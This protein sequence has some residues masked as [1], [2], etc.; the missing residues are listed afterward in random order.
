MP[1]SSYSSRSNVYLDKKI[2]KQDAGN[3]EQVTETTNNYW[4][5][6]WARLKLCLKALVSSQV[7]YSVIFPFKMWQAIADDKLL[8]GDSIVTIDPVVRNAI[9]IHY[10][11]PAAYVG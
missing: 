5:L 6:L 2:Q 4:S 1:Q 3:M 9:A 7:S 10:I 8:Y 11:R